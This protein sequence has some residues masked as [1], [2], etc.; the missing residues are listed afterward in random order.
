MRDVTF[1]LILVAFFA[2]VGAYVAF[3]ERITADDDTDATR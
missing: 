3:C 1:V 2:I